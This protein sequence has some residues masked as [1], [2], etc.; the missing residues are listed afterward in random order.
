MKKYHL[1]LSFSFSYYIP[2]VRNGISY[3]F[4]I[5]CAYTFSDLVFF[6]D[7]RFFAGSNSLFLASVGFFTLS[8][9]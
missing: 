3:Y 1:S 4:G 6:D 8:I 5:V 7:L 9:V 2:F